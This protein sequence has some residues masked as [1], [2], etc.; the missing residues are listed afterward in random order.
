MVEEGGA[1]YWLRASAPAE[2]GWWQLLYP[3]ERFRLRPWSKD[4]PNR[5]LDLDRI[6][7]VRLGYS[8]G[9]RKGFERK[10]LVGDTGLYHP[11]P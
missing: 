9:L 6:V 4:D 3:F 11:L 10:F 8:P 2:P 5:R 7:E 1:V